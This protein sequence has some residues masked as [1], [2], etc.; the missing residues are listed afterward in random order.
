MRDDI[1]Q[2]WVIYG[3]ILDGG[4]FLDGWSLDGNP[5]DIGPPMDSVAPGEIVKEWVTPC[6]TRDITIEVFAE[7]DDAG[8][9]AD[10]DA[11]RDFDSVPGPFGGRR[12]RPERDMLTLDCPKFLATTSRTATFNIGPTGGPGVGV[13]QAEFEVDWTIMR[14]CLTTDDAADRLS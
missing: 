11:R 12:S 1:G 5:V 7:E 13:D 6:E 2:E 3:N 9:N 4:D 8:P 10:D 14:E